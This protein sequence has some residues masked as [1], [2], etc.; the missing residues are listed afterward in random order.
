MALQEYIMTKIKNRQAEEFFKQKFLITTARF[1]ELSAKQHAIA[2]TVAG[3]AD[4]DMLEDIKKAVQVSIDNGTSFNDFK[5]SLMPFLANK[6]WIDDKKKLNNRLRTIYQ[7]NR[8]TAY[9]SGQWERLQNTK[10]T[11][12]YLQ[13]RPSVSTHRRDEHKAYYGIIRH[14][15][16]PIW[17]SIFPPNG[18]GC[19]CF[20]KPLTAKK[21]KEMGISDDKTIEKL[22]TPQ[23]DDNFD[24]LGGLLRLAQDRHG[25]EFAQKLGEEAKIVLRQKQQDL[26]KNKSSNT[27][28]QIALQ[29]W[30][31]NEDVLNKYRTDYQYIDKQ[32]Y[33]LSFVEYALIHHYTTGAY[34]NINAHLNGL[35]EF[36]KQKKMVFNNAKN[37]INNALQR[38]PIFET[39]QVV[40][41]VALS[42]TIIDKYQVGEIITFPAFTSTSYDKDVKINGNENVRFVITHKTGR[43][44]DEISRFSHEHEVLIEAGKQFIVLEKKDVGEYIEIELEQLDDE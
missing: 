24:R 20:V 17:Q 19:K 28:L 4:K 1:D 22:P 37:A 16:D 44:I 40:R 10:D 39:K 27:N 14:I 2:F 26:Q 21:A 23:F 5:K 18:F 29:D 11:F 38:L 7:T 15:D 12:P 43:K 3:L 33:P 9:A 35:I 34:Q 32:K 8:A 42:D 13:Y 36:D 6:G 41:M 31:N 25:K 30:V